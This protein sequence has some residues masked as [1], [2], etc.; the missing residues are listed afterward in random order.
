MKEV[1][2]KNDV[3]EINR[4]LEFIASYCSE[5]QLTEDICFDV[6]LAVEEAVT[7]I[8]KYGYEDHYGHR[9]HVRAFTQPHELIIEIE[10]DAKAFNPLE[11]AEPDLSVPIEER[12]VGG[13]GIYLLRKVMDKVDY[14][15]DGAKNIL[16][17]HKSLHL[18]GES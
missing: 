3:P 1:V 6:Q 7:N 8:I 11:A 18:R 4:V 2:I 12:H 17:M 15:R 5:Q 9:I 14:T 10:D 16:R 13:L